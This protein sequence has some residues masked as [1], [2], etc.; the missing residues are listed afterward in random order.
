MAEHST[1]EPALRAATKDYDILNDLTYFP[2]NHNLV[3]DLLGRVLTQLDAM[4]LP[5]RAHS[6][7]KSLLTREVWR[8]WSFACENSTTSGLGCI[9]PVVMSRE[10][11]PKDDVTAASEPPSNR[12]GWRSEREWHQASAGGK[13]INLTVSGTSAG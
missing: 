9:A 10:S 12:W 5:D 13:G 1:I 7:A 3:R 6:A 2:V 8:W 11:V 4:A